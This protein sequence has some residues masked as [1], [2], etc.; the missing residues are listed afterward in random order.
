MVERRHRSLK[1]AIMGRLHNS[2]STLSE[3]VPT[4]LLGL[5][6]A[7]RIDTGV[8]AGELAFGKT[9][10]LFGQFYDSSEERDPN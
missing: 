8:S 3:D 7:I 1:A 2:S 10:R 6:A 4:V 5:R 9:L